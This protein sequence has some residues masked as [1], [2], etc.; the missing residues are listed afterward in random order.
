MKC[1]VLWKIKPVPK[2]THLSLHNH[3]EASWDAVIPAVLLLARASP[4]AQKVKNPPAMWEAWVGTIP[5]RRA[6]QPTP[7]F[8]PGE[9]PWTEE[10]GGLQS[11]GSQR[12]RQTERLNMTIGKT[13][14]FPF[15]FVSKSL[16]Q[17]VSDGKFLVLWRHFLFLCLKG[18]EIIWNKSMWWSVVGRGWQPAH[19]ALLFWGENVSWV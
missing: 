9:S 1:I 3:M 4:V 15:E 11:K 13:S 6:W 19:L 2:H 7:V 10:P 16:W 14:A 8:F 17:D 18:Q 12:V 5:W